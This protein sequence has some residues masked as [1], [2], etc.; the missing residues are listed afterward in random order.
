[1]NEGFKIIQLRGKDIEF[2]GL[3]SSNLPIDKVQELVHKAEKFAELA[4]QEGDDL[5]EAFDSFL[6]E[7]GVNRVLAEEVSTDRLF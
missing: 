2:A 5:N 3:Y 6:S 1:M 7:N 4:E